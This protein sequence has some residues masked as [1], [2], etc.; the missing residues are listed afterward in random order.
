[1]LHDLEDLR[2]ATVP[3]QGEKDKKKQN[4]DKKQIRMKEIGI[5]ITPARAQTV[6][7]VGLVR[8]T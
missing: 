1:M 6:S 8:R 3:L 5:K 2:V 4:K 7:G